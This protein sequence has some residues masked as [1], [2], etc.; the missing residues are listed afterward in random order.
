[1]EGTEGGLLEGRDHEGFP[2]LEDLLREWRVT[3]AGF[4]AATSAGK[5]DM[6]CV[7]SALK[8]SSGSIT[9]EEMLSCSF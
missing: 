8:H 5:G 3:R 7:Y 4:S 9:V 2:N 6:P 1:M